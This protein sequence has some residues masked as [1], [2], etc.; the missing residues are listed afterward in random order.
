MKCNLFHKIFSATKIK[1]NGLGIEKL[2]KSYPIEIFTK[3]LKSLIFAVNK[4]AKTKTF[5]NH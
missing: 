3:P 1:K 5:Y 2:T 4:F